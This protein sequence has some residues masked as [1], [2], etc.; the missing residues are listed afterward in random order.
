MTFLNDENEV[1]R[2]TGYD[3]VMN[4]TTYPSPQLLELVGKQIAINSNEQLGK[5]ELAVDDVSIM[6][7]DVQKLF[8]DASEA[9]RKGRLKKH[10]LKQHSYYPAK[11][12]KFTK[13]SGSFEYTI[14]ITSIQ[15]TYYSLE[16][17]NKTDWGSWNSFMLVKR[18]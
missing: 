12:M 9:Y 14:V 2:V 3:Y 15:N 18:L 5:I 17:Y 4:I 6:K 11:L 8:N 7:V 16:T 1:L 10:K 13:S